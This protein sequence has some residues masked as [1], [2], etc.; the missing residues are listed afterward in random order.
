M[1]RG[2]KEVESRVESVWVGEESGEDSGTAAGCEEGMFATL[3]GVRW[4]AAGCSVGEPGCCV[5]D[6][7]VDTRE[8]CALLARLS[9]ADI[10]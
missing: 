2:E 10:L 6:E 5:D 7:S 9:V 8:A 4:P 1:R 3:R